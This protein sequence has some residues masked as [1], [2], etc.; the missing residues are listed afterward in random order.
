M[1]QKCITLYV[2]LRE[3]VAGLDLLREKLTD[4]GNGV[5]PQ[6]VLYGESIEKRERGTIIHRLLQHFT[7][8]RNS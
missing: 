5:S 7:T 6:P 8:Q 4:I 1:P 2:S 3:T